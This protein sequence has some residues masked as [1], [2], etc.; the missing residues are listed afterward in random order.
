[1]IQSE[2]VKVLNSNDVKNRDYVV[3]WMQASQRA[4]FNHAL[5]YAVSR[6]NKLN[7]PLIVCFCLTEFPEATLRHYVF[8]LEGLK[9]TQRRL[10]GRRIRLIVRKESPET[11]I[12]EVAKN[13][14][15]VVVDR[16]YLRIQRNWR[17]NVA[18][19][20]SCPLVHVESDLIVPVEEASAKEEYSAATFR[21]KISTKLERFLVPVKEITPSANS[22]G[23]EMDSCSIESIENA[24]SHL[25]INREVDSSKYFPGGTQQ[26]RMLLQ[27]F[28]E[29]KLAGYAD[30]KNDPSEDM[31]SNMS[32][33]L[34]FGQIS[35]LF[36]AL[37][38]RNAEGPG[39][40]S[41][42]EELVVRRELSA[43]FVFYNPNYDSFEGV[44]KWAKE[45]LEDHVH[46]KRRYIYSL[47][48]LEN[49]ETHDEYWNSAQKEMAIR[50][51]MHGYMRMYWG[52]KILEWTTTPQEAYRRAIYLNNKYE[53]DG[54]DPNGFAGVA[55]C[56][57]KHD[58]PWGTRE[59]F[60]NIRYMNSEGLER[61]FDMSVYVK[62]V[63]RLRQTNTS[64]V[65]GAR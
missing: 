38:V 44:P 49:A 56:F 32:P 57:G 19:N 27:T 50:G 52:K 58:R 5:E 23:L 9:E 37:S 54:R 15:M 51:K 63:E 6:A 34:H 64:S 24:L 48:E 46:D 55:W 17:D 33:Y 59:I 7:R 25:R 14:S 21:P 65:E 28:I 35:P 10:L 11:A 60:G 29:G 26:A 4:E 43:N 42:L 45:T 62:N 30:T 40:G 3:Y 31:L 47:Q 41:F 18:R 39:K 8:M 12:A 20:I 22:E 1:M 16:G 36:V 53:L 2:R 13:A 61:K